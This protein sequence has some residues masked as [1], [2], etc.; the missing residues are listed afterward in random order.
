MGE[1]M[2]KAKPEK[3]AQARDLRQ[4]GWSYRSIAKELKVS[5]SSVSLWCSNVEI[6]AEQ[7]QILHSNLSQKGDANMGA[8]HNK[9]K[10]LEERRA[11]QELGR[12]K[13]REKRKWHV[14]GCMLY[15]AEGGKTERSKIDFANSDAD[16]IKIFMKFLREE[17]LIPDEQINIQIYCYAQNNEERLIVENYWRDQLQ[18]P[19]L[20]LYATQVL[21]GTEA[22]HNRLSMGVCSIRIHSTEYTQHIYGAIQ[23][24]GGF[25]NEEWLY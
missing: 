16:M 14:I 13:A 25:V 2:V 4:Q 21:E 7:A 10:G 19:S 15:W 8:K 23:E 11:Y 24:Y 20:I 1:I 5:M 6:T 3:Q 22:K 9:A 12:I 18:L 17:L